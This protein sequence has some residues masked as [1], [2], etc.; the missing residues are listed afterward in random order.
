MIVVESMGGNVSRGNGRTR[1]LRGPILLVFLSAFLGPGLGRTLLAGS[2]DS[3]D[4]RVRVVTVNVWSGLDYHGAIRFGEY[5]SRERREARFRTLI[6]D[7]RSVA[8]DVLFIQE[9]NPAD[10]FSARLADSLGLDEI[11][12]VSNAGV[13]VAGFGPPLNFEEGIAT[14]A[15]KDLRIKEYSVWKLSG[16]FGLFGD[17][18][19]LN[20]DEAEFAQVGTVTLREGR[21][22]LV[23]V[24]LSSTPPPDSTLLAELTAA[25]DGRVISRSDSSMAQAK[26]EAGATRRKDEVARLLE[27]IRGL[28]PGDPVIL[29]GDFN[30]KPA[31]DEIKMI[32]NSGLFPDAERTVCTGFTWDPGRNSN[33]AYSTRLVDA[34]GHRFDFDDTL[35]ALYDTRGRTIDYIF[36]SKHFD[37]SGIS[38][39]HVIHDSDDEA[40]TSSDHFG[41]MSDVTANCTT[42]GALDFEEGGSGRRSIEPLPIVSYDTDIGFGY[43]AKLF[44][45]DLLGAKE[46]CDLVLFNS[47]KGERWYR[48]VLSFPDIEWREGRVYPFAFD[49][50]FDYDKWLKNN[51]YG[52]GDGSPFASREQYTRIPMEL[53]ASFSRGFL[54]EF[55]GQISFKFRRIENTGFTP[56]SELLRL[57]PGLNA[58][59]VRYLSAGLSVR[60]DTRNSFVNP[61]NG[62]V[63]QFETEYAPGGTMGNV[64]FVRAAGWLQY[65]RRLFYPT[66][67][68]AV[69]LG[70]QEV[71]GDDLP[72][73]L[74]SSIGGNNTLRGFTQDR[75][76]DKVASV[77][78]TELRFPIFWRLG[79]V[80]GIDAGKVWR[81]L[82]DFDVSRWRVN[83]VVGLRL[84][85][86]NFVVRADLGIGT[87]GTGF[88]F[89]FGQLF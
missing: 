6:R 34:S 16:S 3:C 49:L 63:L 71:E 2:R 20:F 27:F 15:R 35:S 53:S 55:V 39:A 78:N 18:V 87:E 68:L 24:H 38:R 45:F 79:A 23:N 89:N 13:K 84:Y 86:D 59:T 70:V 1:S 82:S 22:F 83:R 51:F 54:P 50:L 73:Q 7:L 11:H 65:Y 33:I 25:R 56:Y 28:P 8:P 48:G 29:G 46:S 88:Y 52:V 31:S 57:P 37:S 12:Q 10:E 5:E 67:V 4:E 77:L 60:Y 80:V 26:L 81:V 44:L 72:V 9:A 74:L 36:F 43:G 41:I 62:S 85:M 61:S 32:V 19:T 64:S 76:L 30:A 69:R 40:L 58:G 17:D 42:A 14:L 66:T 47:T 75:F 21:V